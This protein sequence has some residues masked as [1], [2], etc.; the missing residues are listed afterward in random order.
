MHQRT[1]V[2]DL[3]GTLATYDGWKGPKV[4]GAPIKNARNA[5]LELKEWGWRVV[6]FTTR[7]DKDL[8]KYW[9]D[10]HSMPY[11][12]INDNSHNPPG[13]SQKPIA[14]V[15]FDDNDAHCVKERP[16][17]WKRAMKR[18][19]KIFQP[20]PITTEIDDAA[21]WSSWFYKSKDARQPGELGYNSLIGE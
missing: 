11:D 8:V 19:R 9:L 13:C 6:I 3:D 14:D 2:I 7:G 10:T 18:V 16:Y 17:N 12:L 21:A 4:I 20:K 15:Y 1:A 5:L